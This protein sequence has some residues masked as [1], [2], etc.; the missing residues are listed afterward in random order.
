[1]RAATLLGAALLVVALA[2]AL[3][4]SDDDRPVD[5]ER[6]D[7]QRA[8]ATARAIVDGELVDVRIDTDNGKWEVTLRRDDGGEHEVELSPASSSCCGSTTTE[9]REPV[10]HAAH[11]LE[12]LGPELAAQVADVDV[13]DVGAGVEVVAPD[14][15]E[16]LLAAEDLARVAQERLQQ[17]ELLGRQLGLAAALARRRGACG[18]RA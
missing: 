4:L 3:S 1:M 13:D 9:R 16:Q 15:R 2:L 8:I 6:P 14:V 7:A 5:P 17:R 10:P 12:A 11:G 18:R